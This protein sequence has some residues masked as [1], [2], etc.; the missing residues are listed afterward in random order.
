MLAGEGH[1]PLAC[2]PQPSSA[3]PIS[4]AVD[5]CEVTF[6]HDMHI[7]RI[8]ESPRVWPYTD[9]QWRAV[10]NLGEQVDAELVAGDVRPTMGGEPT[11]VSVDDRDGAEWNTGKSPQ[12][13][14]LQNL[15]RHDDLLG[16]RPS[17]LR[18]ERNADRIAYTFLQQNTEC[19]RR[20][21]NALTAHTGL[22]QPQ[23][24]RIVTALR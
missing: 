24:Q 2:T 12:T 22:G 13:H 6:G 19:R 7:T 17:R 3:A 18:R 8:W 21:H 23:M 16:P 14:A 5:E 11:F 10:L 15:L 4:G 1:I 20:R 9:D